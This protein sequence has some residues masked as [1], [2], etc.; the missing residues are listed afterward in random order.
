MNAVKELQKL[1]KRVAEA[2]RE[3]REAE[4]GQRDAQ[5]QLEAVKLRWTEH[6]ASEDHDPLPADLHNA[7]NDAEREAVGRDDRRKAAASHAAPR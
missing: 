4:Q 2:E 3:V 6:F 7:Q 5:A 1:E